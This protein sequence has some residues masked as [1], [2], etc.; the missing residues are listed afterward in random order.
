[1]TNRSW[2]ALLRSDKPTQM[3]M[4]PPPKLASSHCVRGWHSLV[5][6]QPSYMGEVCQSHPMEDYLLGRWWR[7]DATRENG[8]VVTQQ[9]TSK[10]SLGWKN[11]KLQLG[12]WMSTRA[13]TEDGWRP[14]VKWFGCRP[15]E[16]L[17]CK[18]EGW[19]LYPLMLADSEPKEECYHSLSWVMAGKANQM[20]WGEWNGKQPMCQD[21]G[22]KVYHF[23]AECSY[24]PRGTYTDY[25]GMALTLQSSQAKMTEHEV[26]LLKRK[27]G[28]VHTDP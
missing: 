12:S 13:S 24:L 21:E 3:V 9:P 22:P 2:C 15:L 17:V 10:A 5:N 20:N 8:K 11:R 25:W 27:K 1:M 23:N 7:E 28:G 4:S 19:H 26:M 18:A 6:G 14:Q 16:E